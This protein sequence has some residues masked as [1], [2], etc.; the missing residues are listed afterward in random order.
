MLPYFIGT[1]GMLVIK[2][3]CMENDKMGVADGLQSVLDLHLRSL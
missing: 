1:V 2:G 3:A